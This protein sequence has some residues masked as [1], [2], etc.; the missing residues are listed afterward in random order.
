MF[1]AVLL[2]SFPQ[3]AGAVKKLLEMEF[4]RERLE[5]LTERIGTERVE[6]RQLEVET[7]AELTLMQKLEGPAGV[8]PPVA[9]AVMGDGGRLKKMQAQ[10]DSLKHW[11]EYKAALFLEL[12]SLHDAN[13]PTAPTSDPCPQVPEF[14]TN[15]EQVETLTREMAQLAASGSKT[16]LEN[17]EDE[18]LGIDL[19]SLSSSTTVSQL[20][21]AAA[22]VTTAQKRTSRDLPLSPRLKS[23]DV[24]AT[25]DDARCFGRLIVARAWTLG[26][27]QGFSKP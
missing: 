25:L 12:G 2:K 6:Q 27:F 10:P 16:T 17:L 26:M 3:A 19:E 1:V 23:R 15:F 4:G 13:D 21:A 5:R 7:V 22:A 9:C 18:D 11:Y 8:T 20:L 14:L 24:V